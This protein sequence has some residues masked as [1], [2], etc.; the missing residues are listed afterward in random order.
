METYKSYKPSGVEWIG[1]IPADWNVKKLKFSTITNEMVLPE[2]TEENFSFRYIDIGSVDGM[3][4]I[5]DSEEI[6]FGEAPSRARRIVKYGDT[7]ISTVRTYLKAI[8][9]IPEDSENR[10]CSTGFAVVSPLQEYFVPKYLFYLCRSE[11]FVDEVCSLSEGVSYPA[12]DS[13]S[14]RNIFALIPSQPEQTAIATYLDEETEQI[15][16]LVA[17]KQK[18]IALLKEERTAIINHAIT[19]GIDPSAEL[20]RSGLDWLDNI[21]EHWKIR[22]LKY[23]VLVKARLGWKGLKANEYV[24]EGYGF[25]STPNI[26]PKDIDFENINYITKERYFESPEIMLEDG[27]VLLAKDGSTLG[28]VNVVKSLPFPSTVN[29]SI[30]VLRIT[31]KEELSPNFLRL[32]LASDYCQ[33][34]IQMIK[35]GMGV[36]HLFQADIREFNLP[37]PPLPEQAEIVDEIKTKTSHIDVTISRV[38]SEVMLMQEYRTALISEVVTGKVKVV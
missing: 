37:L 35:D 36:P 33:N 38:E 8:A 31:D 20:K 18:L 32:F 17:N 16:K 21:P 12:I 27:D 24:P 28:T 10:I 1:D 34:V 4:N 2:K 19:K 26:K 15:D 25:L 7:I 11:R 30:A 3:G 9:F 6:I 14:L 22:R 5:L 29:S 23:V 13:D